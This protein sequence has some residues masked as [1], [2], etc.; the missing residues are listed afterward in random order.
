MNCCSAC[1]RCGSAGRLC[2]RSG[3]HATIV[4]RADGAAPNRLPALRV[5]ALGVVPPY[6]AVHRYSHARAQLISREATLPSDAR[7]LAAQGGSWIAYATTS[8]PSE[9]VRTWLLRRILARGT[10]ARSSIAPSAVRCW[11]PVGILSAIRRHLKFVM[12]AAFTCVGDEIDRQIEAL[13][14]V[15][16]TL[17][18]TRANVAASGP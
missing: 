5:I 2:A 6:L 3:R 7:V 16:A 9:E 12:A 11:S 8:E 13:D 1:C 17:S 4:S 15:I 14:L 18:Q 10:R